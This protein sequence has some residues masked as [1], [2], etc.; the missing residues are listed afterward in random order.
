MVLHYEPDLESPGSDY[1]WQLRLPCHPR[2]ALFKE[3]GLMILNDTLTYLQLQRPG[4]AAV[5]LRGY[6]CPA[7]RQAFKWSLSSGWWRIAW[8]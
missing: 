7:G 3:S 6:A 8:Y 2:R 1:F 5:T 4:C